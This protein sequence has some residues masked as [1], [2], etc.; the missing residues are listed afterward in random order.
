MSLDASSTSGSSLMF[1]SIKDWEDEMM[2]KPTAWLIPE[3]G[4]ETQNESP[5]SFTN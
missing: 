3:Q 2:E 5:A 4:E 1:S